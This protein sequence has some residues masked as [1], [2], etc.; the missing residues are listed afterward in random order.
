MRQVAP[1]GAK[2]WFASTPAHFCAILGHFQSFSKGSRY[3]RTNYQTSACSSHL[4]RRTLF[5]TLKMERNPGEFEIPKVLHPKAQPKNRLRSLAS[6]IIVP[7]LPSEKT[8]LA[9]YSRVKSLEPGPVTMTVPMLAEAS[10]A[11]HATVIERLKDLHAQQRI[12]LSKYSGGRPWSYEEF[13][14]DTTKFFSV[15]AFRVEILPEGRKYFEQLEAAAEKEVSQA[16]AAEREAS[17]TAPALKQTVFVSCGQRT[18][19]E[20]ELGRQIFDV[21][22]EH[23]AFCAYFADLQSSLRGLNE[24][25]LDALGNCVGFVAVMHPRGTVSF[26]KGQGFVRASVWVEQEIAIAAYIQRTRKERLHVAAYAHKSVEREGLRELLQLNPMLF[27]DSAEVPAHLRQ[28]LQSWR[29]VASREL[30]SRGEVA[31]ANLKAVRGSTPQLKTANIF[32]SIENVG[33][34]R[35][36]EY[37]ATISVPADALTFS[38]TRYPSEVP[39]RIDGYR[40][41][42][43]TERNQGGVAIHTGDNFQVISVETAVEHLNAERRAE[44]LK[45]EVI[46]DVEANGESLQVRKSLGDLMNAV[47]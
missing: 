31:S 37:A 8:E 11:D 28:A 42:R 45:M 33:R 21:I 5:G 40:S 34:G 19:E 22:N 36:R 47:R 43:H 24:N 17:Q 44:I 27:T 12:A 39:S 25:I 4:R 29:P 3:K 30:P 14:D 7:M 46:G 20:R 32:L 18:D 16:A 9:M 26:S 38:A 6:G 15:G 23:P 1:E 2:T 13:K 41:F 35:I 10:G